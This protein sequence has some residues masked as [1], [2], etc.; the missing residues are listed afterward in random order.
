MNL[1]FTG[2]R[3]LYSDVR[4]QIA[5]E[6]I[7][8]YQLA[9]L[10]SKN[11]RVLDIGC[12]SGYGSQIL[13]NAHSYLGVDIS[14]EA[15]EACRQKFNAPNVSFRVA[16]ASNLDFGDQEFDLITCFEV[17]EHVEHPED[18]VRQVKRVLSSTGIFVSSTPDKETYNSVLSEPNSYHLHEMTKAEYSNMLHSS[19]HFNRLLG[20][21][22]VQSSFIYDPD[23]R[24]NQ[25]TEFAENVESNVNQTSL[26]IYWIALSSDSN[27]SNFDVQSLHRS[28]FSRNL[29]GELVHMI[30][31]TKIFY[32]QLKEI[33]TNQPES[34]IYRI[35]N[36]L[37]WR[38]N[39]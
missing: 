29:G 37:L 28:T 5:V 32:D 4:D 27:L 22:F 39:V 38:K 12:G 17:L 34:L 24:T 11:L 1:E 33:E 35:L 14:D 36:R 25:W 10:F 16:D 23:S 15:V 18:I 7:H 2:E 21:N 31:Q 3:F 8:R 26:P 9:A 19:F 13:R 20:Q 30:K 6:H